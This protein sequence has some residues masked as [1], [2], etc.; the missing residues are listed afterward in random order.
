MLTRGEVVGGGA[1]GICSFGQ[2]PRGRVGEWAS[3]VGWGMDKGQ[4]RLGREK[5]CR[6]T[7]RQSPAAAGLSTPVDTQLPDGSWC[8]V[9]MYLVG[10]TCGPIHTY[11]VDV[12]FSLDGGLDGGVVCSCDAAPPCPPEN[13]QDLFPA[14]RGWI[15]RRLIRIASCTMAYHRTVAGRYMVHM[16]VLMVPP[17]SGAS[18]G[19]AHYGF[20]LFTTKYHGR[21]STPISRERV[22]S[23]A[24]T[25]VVVRAPV[26][27]WETVKHYPSTFC[28]S[29]IAMS[30]CGPLTDDV[31]GCRLGGAGSGHPGYQQVRLRRPFRYFL[32]PDVDCPATHMKPLSQHRQRQQNRRRQWQPWNPG[33]AA[34]RS[35]SAAL[36]LC[37]CESHAGTSG[38]LETSGQ[39]T[40]RCSGGSLSG[41]KS[42]PR[43]A[44]RWCPPV[45]IS[46]RLV[47]RPEL[48]DGWWLSMR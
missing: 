17:L 22:S 36:P 10:R 11:I 37:R 6:N 1:G 16:C 46:L 25:M 20:R 4:G 2:Q 42:L 23:C 34:R 12:D 30:N 21:S 15:Q 43:S 48:V 26:T 35:C 14:S 41:S 47:G 9:R 3:R 33:P 29:R 28:K 13:K 39:T 32:V 18:R 38:A 24:V 31:W 8:P 5:R 40:R 44:K 27:E 45:K 7:P 19:A